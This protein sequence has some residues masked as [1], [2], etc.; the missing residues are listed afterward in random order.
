MK[1]IF[2]F[3]VFLFSVESIYSS[4]F[5]IRTCNELVKCTC[6]DSPGSSSYFKELSVF[7]MRIDTKIGHLVIT[8][9]SSDTIEVNPA[10]LFLGQHINSD[11]FDSLLG[12]NA[13]ESGIY[14]LSTEI[15]IRVVERLY[16]HANRFNFTGLSSFGSI[17]TAI[18]NYHDTKDINNRLKDFFERGIFI[19]PG[20][21]KLL[22]F[23]GRSRAFNFFN[24]RLKNRNVSLKN[25]IVS[26]C[27]STSYLSLEN[28]YNTLHQV[29][30]QP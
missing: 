2:L 3:F 20:E 27:G 10:N 18:G 21:S 15:L 9:N 26:E 12:E 13:D 25:E 30:V 11:T 6:Y 4:V 1:K 8:N 24:E 16:S 29:K 19:N 14:V 22:Y 28:L 17:G 23:W 7:L 5:E